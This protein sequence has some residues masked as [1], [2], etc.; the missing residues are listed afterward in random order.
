MPPE[1]RAA[2]IAVVGGGA[3]G[4]AAAIFCAGAAAA[5]T[6]VAVLD[7]ARLLG[8]KILV[9]GGGRCNVTNERVTP[10]DYHGPRALI[11]RVLA[12]FS[13][14]RTAEWFSDLGVALKTEETGKVFPVAD[15]A[16][17]VVDA[18]LARCAA[19]GVAILTERRVSAVEPAATGYLVRHAGGDL[20]A[21]RVVLATGG[22]SLPRTGSDGHGYALARALG[23][24][25]TPTHPALVPLLLD[26]AF[27]HAALSGV[28]HEA[29]LTTLADGKVADRR[30]GSLLWTHFGVSGP[31]A[32]DASRHYLAAKAAGAAAEVR[33]SF[34]P[35][36]D[37]A[38][39]DRR[40]IASDRRTVGAALS[41]MLPQRVAE[42]VARSAGVL[43]DRPFA[44]LARED[45]RRLAHALAGLPLPVI[46]DRGY[47]F[48]EVTAGGV[49]LAEVDVRT[50]ESRVRP[51]LFLAGE[52]L[53][54]DGR[55]GGFNFQWAWATGFLAG[56]G[57]ARGAGSRAEG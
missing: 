56:H 12:A 20:P 55:I 6:R 53:D 32:L 37:V 16:R 57:A 11:R 43:P 41:A 33:C 13:E 30:R 17:V 28:S 24:T 21:A 1:E 18:L 42:A 38:G 4:L 45:R 35:G 49:P 5:G 19:L 36:E 34:L 22:L 7:S 2:D 8:A 47:G 52:I 40:L 50:M 10:S 51:G 29:E 9:S 3:A 39:V 26:P 54:V 27:C 46:G 15:R 23:H 48:A 31:V 44:G 25:V 14:R